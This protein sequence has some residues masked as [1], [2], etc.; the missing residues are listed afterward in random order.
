[1]KTGRALIALAA[2][3]LILWVAAF[4][5]EIGARDAR[6][7]I[8]EA[9]HLDNAKDVHIRSISEGMGG[10]AIVEASIDAA[11]RFEKDKSGKWKAVEVRTGDQTWESFE[12]IETALRKE[13]ILRTTADMRAISVAI[14]AFRRERG[15]YIAAKTAAALIDNLSPVYLGPIIRRDAWSREFQYT[16]SEGGYRLA[17]LGPDGR[18]ETGDEIVIENGQIV[19]GAAE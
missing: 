7:R 18:A 3:L 17:S 19:K 2:G 11:F 9:L 12:L 4:A 10:Q 15:H 5:G 1:M 16:G 6:L 8:A 13:K 14:E